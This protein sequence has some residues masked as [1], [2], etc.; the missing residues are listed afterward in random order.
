MSPDLAEFAQQLRAHRV[1]GAT[2]PVLLG[3][4]GTVDRLYSVVGRRDG[5]RDNFTAIPDIGQFGR[6]ISAAAGQSANLELYPR[7]AKI[8]GNGPIMARALAAHG[9]DLTYIGPLGPRGAEPVFAELEQSATIH[10]VGS[11]AVTHALEFEDGKIMLP[12]LLTYEDVTAERI[13]ATVGRE[14]LL[15]VL[16]RVRLAALLNWTC[17]PGMDGIFDLFLKEL[18]PVVG[19]DSTRLFFFDLADP[20]KHAPERIAGV[21]RRIAEFER[22]GSV[23]LGL[24]FSE[25]AQATRALGLTVPTREPAALQAAAAELRSALG[26]SVIMI[27]PTEC[28]VCATAAGT[29]HVPGPVC[30]RPLITTGAGDHLNSGFCL[31]LLLKLPP[32]SC[33]RLGVLVSGYYVRTGRSPTLDDILTFLPE[34]YA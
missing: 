9:L 23:V 7:L 28:A 8:G 3:F 25:A 29:F 12:V 27:H 10:S 16:R 17:L 26:V 13:L 32:A 4:D 33:L 11:P 22:F 19:P 24:N 5:P 18:L 2:L 14:P 21:L 20:A 30:A 6:Q 34:A 1:P 31:G 15:A